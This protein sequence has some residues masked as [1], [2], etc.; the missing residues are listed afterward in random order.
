MVGQL[1]AHEGHAARRGVLDLLHGHQPRRVSRSDHHRLS[2]PGSEASARAD[3]LGHGSELRVALGLRRRRRRHDARPD[4]VRARRARARHGRAARRRP[5][6]SRR[7]ASGRAIRSQAIRIGRRPARARSPRRRHRD[8]RPADHD[9]AGHR[10]LQLPAARASSSR[11]SPGSSSAGQW[12]PV[13]RKRLYV[14]FVYLRRGRAVLVGLRAG[15]IHAESVRGPQHEQRAPRLRT[16]P[17]SW[18]QSLN[19]LLHLRRSRR[20]SRG[21]GSS[22]ARGSRRR[23][24]KFALGLVG[25][26]LGFLVL[27]ARR[28]DRR[29]P[30]RRS[31]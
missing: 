1:Y 14:I 15:R 17:S 6:P 28:A 10:R 12:T 30:A 26:G 22:S 16:F 4:P 20:C 9:R 5:D 2:R 24:T 29:R 25:V 3:G 23:P 7:A 31:A 18:W 11:S 21:S 13:E 19:A 8:R 27:D